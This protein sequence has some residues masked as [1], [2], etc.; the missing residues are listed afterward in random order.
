[1]DEYKMKKI[2]IL[3]RDC[4]GVNTAIR[5]VVRTANS[6]NIETF[7]IIRGYDGLIDN[8][9]IPLKSRDVSGIINRGGT[10]LKT[11]RSKRFF[12]DEGQKIAVNNI[13][14]N[15]F[16]GLIVIGGNGSLKGAHI[17]ASKYNIPI[18]GIPATIDNDIY[19]VDFSIGSDTAINVALDAIDKIRDTATS[20]ERI[21]IVEVM[22][23]NCGYIALNVAL[24]A[25]C[26]DVFVPEM[27]VNVEKTCQ[28]IKEGNRKGKKSWIIIVSEGLLKTNFISN[29]INEKTGLETRISVLGHIQRGGSPTAF[30]RILAS[31]LGSYAV[32]MF[33]DGMNNHYVSIK[34]KKLV[35]LPLNLIVNPKKISVLDRYTLIK[36]LT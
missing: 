21:F 10:I 31:K 29:F 15:D 9:F 1:M 12:S 13:K 34:N 8:N 19:G 11:S 33:K 14:N 16:D 25:G 35:V 32:E 6:Y 20:L 18:I 22:G 36:S 23:R 2:A 26:E 5:A 7:G 17:L 24:A 30:D 28:E 27:D 3:S 4:S